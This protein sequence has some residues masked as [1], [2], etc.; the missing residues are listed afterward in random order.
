M[1]VELLLVL[2]IIGIS[3]NTHL[4]RKLATVT[5]DSCEK[6]GKKYQEAKSATCKAG[7]SVFA[8]TKKEE[9][10]AGTWTKGR[11]S[12]VEVKEADCKGIPAYSSGSTDKDTDTDGDK[13]TDTDG[14]KDSGTDSGADTDSQDPQ[15]PTTNPDQ[16]TETTP[17]SRLRAVADT[18]ATCKTTSGYSIK[19]SSRLASKAACEVELKW[20][21]NSGICSTSTEVK[22]ESDCT[23][24]NPEYIDA[25]EATCVDGSNSLSFKIALAFVI[26][27]LF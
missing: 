22:T 7:D 20:D 9:C 12:L 27:L 19:D 8:V 17:Q 18:S 10:K 14:D 1:R 21:A 15:T 16:E 23:K 6:E 26:C 3:L 24:A 4:Q 2:A 11:C 25:T 13:D 5:K